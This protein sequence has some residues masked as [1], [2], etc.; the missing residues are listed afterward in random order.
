[1]ADLR[2]K[3]H[4]KCK[5]IKLRKA[6]P[7]NLRYLGLEHFDEGRSR[8]KWQIGDRGLEHTRQV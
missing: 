6:A 8:G 7:G 3:K 2:W 4:R 1:M 5:K